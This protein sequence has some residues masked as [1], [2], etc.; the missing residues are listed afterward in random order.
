[1]SEYRITSMAG[2]WAS[3]FWS[4]ETRHTVEVAEA[5]EGLW[6]IPGVQ[7]HPLA[8]DV[9]HT[10]WRTQE[11]VAFATLVGIDPDC[12]QEDFVDRLTLRD[13]EPLGHARLV[14]HLDAQHYEMRPAFPH[15]RAAAVAIAESGGLLL[16]DEMG[17]GKTQSALLAAHYVSAFQRETVGVSREPKI[18]MGPLFTRAVWLS[19]LRSLGLVE[20]ESDVCVLQGK[21]NDASCFDDK[22]EWYFCHYD[23]VHEWFPRFAGRPP[24]VV[25]ADEAHYLRNAKTARSRGAAV[26]LGSALFR[27]LLTG[28]PI[29]NKPQDLHALLSMVSGKGTWGS[30]TDFRI[31]YAG[32]RP[33]PF[34]GFVDGEP[35]NTSELRQRMAPYYL[36][37]TVDDAGGNLPG[38]TRSPIKVQLSGKRRDVYMG[39]IQNS[40]VTPE[41]LLAA[42]EN[43]ANEE[44]LSLIHQLRELTS[45]AKRETTIE[46]IQSMRDQGEAC[47]VF[48]WSRAQAEY[49]HR[50]LDRSDAFCVHGGFPIEAR[51]QCI[52]EFQ[53][54]GQEGRAALLVATYGALREGVTLHAARHVVFHDLDWSPAAIAQAEK[55]IHR[56]GQTRACTS[57]WIVAERTIDTLFARA[58]VSKVA[59][60]DASIGIDYGFTNLAQSLGDSVV[61]DLAT[62][63]AQALE[64]WR[65]WRKA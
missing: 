61:V 15:Q 32:A 17:L 19:E 10:A 27:I 34:R 7:Q 33:G 42:L 23:V 39:H 53:E 58:L 6:E 13:P 54:M 29:E 41:D 35:T 45:D 14:E 22:A 55:R 48:T 21:R 18:I 65:K 31:R 16:A 5:L 12:L 2:L 56:I 24:L 62:E 47:V 20:R 50:R 57:H 44:A 49:L 38:F 37:R 59:H 9:P 36:R 3:V 43:G 11:W 64:E 4:R 51:D 30:L 8:V 40:R 60:A 63:V 46:L 1:M 52:R 28:T 25:I 26:M